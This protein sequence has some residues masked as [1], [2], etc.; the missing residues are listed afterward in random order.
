MKVL[1]HWRV[2]VTL[3][4]L[5]VSGLVI[6]VLWTNSQKHDKMNAKFPEVSGENLQGRA[7]VFPRDFQSNRVLV[8]FAYEREQADALSSWVKGLELLDSHIEWYETPI[9]SKPLQLGSW[10]IDGGMR[11]GIQE[12]RVQERVITIYTNR[13]KFAS[14]VGVPFEMQG[15]YAMVLRRD[16][17]VVGYAEGAF[18]SNGAKRISQWL[19]GND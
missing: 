3:I 16:G 6:D 2:W 7:F 15:A 13:E 9:I 19:M 8:L 17:S 5:I 11:K 12:V 10:F 4:V 18:T 14:A 1:L